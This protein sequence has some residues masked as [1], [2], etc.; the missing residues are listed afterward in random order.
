MKSTGSSFTTSAYSV[1]NAWGG[2]GYTWS[3]DFNGDGRADIASANGGNI[4]MKL[5]NS[6]GTGFVSATWGA[7]NLWGGSDYT[8]V[9]DFDGNGLA[10]IASAN[11]TNVYM[12]LS[13]G[14]GFISQVWTVP[15]GTWGGSSYTRVGK[16]SLPSSN[17]TDIVSQVGCTVY[18][19]VSTG[20]GFVTIAS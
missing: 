2:S 5:A 3:A 12:K 19:H 20:S 17:R 1:A 9:G 16:F 14:G 10:D 11:G 7:A 15:A 4:Y 13:T 18:H 6:S 8:W